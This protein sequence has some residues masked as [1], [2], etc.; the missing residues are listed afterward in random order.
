MSMDNWKWLTCQVF[1]LKEKRNFKML[2]LKY[3][4]NSHTGRE[5]LGS[6]QSRIYCTIKNA[7]CALVILKFNIPVHSKIS[8]SWSGCGLP[9]LC[10][11]SLLCWPG[12]GIPRYCFENTEAILASLP[13]GPS[14]V[15]SKIPVGIYVNLS[16]S[17]DQ[18]E[19]DKIIRTRMGLSVRELTQ[20]W[21]PALWK[22]L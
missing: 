17:S 7:E 5:I 22:A 11:L 14:L 19:G 3:R 9:L 6:A 15:H 16:G 8:R 13:L 18:A 20:W 1:I 10:H 21:Q 12:S 2:W 4:T